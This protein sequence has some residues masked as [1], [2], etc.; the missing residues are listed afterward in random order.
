MTE[1]IVSLDPDKARH[2]S[3][4]DNTLVLMRFLK[5]F[6]SVKDVR[7]FGRGRTAEVSVA[8]ADY[9]RMKES[10]EVSVG[11]NVRAVPFPEK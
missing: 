10:D 9:L 7:I 4:D 8:E 11:L 1:A 6:S 5:S 3:V 2:R